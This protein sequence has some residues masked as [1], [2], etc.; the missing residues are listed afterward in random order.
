M[1][2]VIKEVHP[3][4]GESTLENQQSC[5][6]T[7]SNDATDT[8]GHSQRVQRSGKELANF[9]NAGASGYVIPAAETILRMLN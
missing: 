4:L 2:M 7:W 5:L 8:T 6:L 1:S 9:F 3:Y